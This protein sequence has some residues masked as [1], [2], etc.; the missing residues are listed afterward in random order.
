MRG[1]C[2]PSGVS[3]FVILS[4]A[5]DPVTARTSHAASMHS[6]PNAHRTIRMPVSTPADAG[7]AG[8]FTS[9]RKTEIQGMSKVQALAT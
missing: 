4:K 2:M 6:H 7:V 5:K 9:F 1:K 3:R 8:S